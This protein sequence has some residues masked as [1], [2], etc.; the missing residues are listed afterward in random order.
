MPPFPLEVRR[1]LSHDTPIHRTPARLGGTFRCP[2]NGNFACLMRTPTGHWYWS[3]P[4]TKGCFHTGRPG[5]L[6]SPVPRHQSWFLFM[7]GFDLRIATSGRRYDSRTSTPS[8]MAKRSRCE[9]SLIGRRLCVGLV[10]K[11][12]VAENGFRLNLN[13]IPMAVLRCPC[14]LNEMGH[15]VA[16]LDS[17]LLLPNPGCFRGCPSFFK[18]AAGTLP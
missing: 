18:K 3:F 2:R 5:Q 13:G 6:R 12:R 1:E 8:L 9:H 10:P 7:H 15:D 11:F 16:G 14:G 17:R 4:T